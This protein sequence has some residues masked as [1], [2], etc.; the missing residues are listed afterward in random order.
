MRAWII[1]ASILLAG[2]SAF[3]VHNG[4]KAYNN[5]DISG[6]ADHWIKG[7]QAGHPEAIY[8]LGRLAENGQLQGPSTA[9]DYYLESARKG[10]IPAMTALAA[11]Q[12]R[13]GY[14]DAAQ[15]WATKA[16]SYGDA[17][18]SEMLAGRGLPVPASGSLGL[19]LSDLAML[20]AMG[21]MG[22]ARRSTTPPPATPPTY[23]CTGA[24]YSIVC[25]PQ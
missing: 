14:S 7:A 12:W 18:A 3:D 1:C 5:G 23:N 8:Y 11:L 22:T 4:I 15:S 20:G 17:E 24:G 13:L 10:F 6:A 19:T 9:A 16:A 25:R 2:C 21:F